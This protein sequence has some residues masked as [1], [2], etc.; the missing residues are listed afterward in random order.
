MKVSAPSRGSRYLSALA[1]GATRQSCSF[2]PPAGSKGSE[3]NW[4]QRCHWR[5]VVS[6][7]FRGIYIIWSFGTV[8]I[9]QV[10]KSFRPLPRIKVSEQLRLLRTRHESDGFRPLTGIKVSEQTKYFLIVRAQACFRPLSGIKVS[11]LL[12]WSN[13]RLVL[14][15]RFRPLAGS[16]ASERDEIVSFSASTNGFRPLTGIKVSEQL[17]TPY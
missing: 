7:P 1:S 16:K 3:R 9:A 10:D 13:L 17:L 8:T 2:R 6:V 4:W 5:T 11:E 12:V 15:L 14:K